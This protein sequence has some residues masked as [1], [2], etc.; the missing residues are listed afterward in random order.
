MHFH[1]NACNPLLIGT[2]LH[3]NMCKHFCCLANSV[4]I[5]L[6]SIDFRVVMRIVNTVF[7]CLSKLIG[8]GP[9]ELEA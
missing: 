2:L 6:L 9:L 5:G 4:G 1:R 8:T 3:R 7:G